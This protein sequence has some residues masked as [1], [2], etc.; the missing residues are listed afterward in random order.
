[1]SALD[2]GAKSF[3][4]TLKEVG[5]DKAVSEALIG[6]GVGIGGNMAYNVATGDSGGY[7]GAAL[8]GG[9]AGGLGRAGL[10]HF[11]LETQ[12]SNLFSTMKTGSVGAMTKAQKTMGTKSN[13]PAG[14]ILRDGNNER[15]IDDYIKRE[16]ELN[17]QA[18]KLSSKGY[19]SQAD[20]ILSEANAVGIRRKEKQSNQFRQFSKN[21]TPGELEDMY[22][23][24]G[25]ASY[26]KDNLDP[27]FRSVSD[28]VTDNKK[29]LSDYK[30]KGLANVRG[31]GQTNTPLLEYK[32]PA[33]QEAIRLP[34]GTVERNP[35]NRVFSERIR[36][37]DQVPNSFGVPDIIPPESK[38]SSNYKP[39]NYMEANNGNF[40]GEIPK[41]MPGTNYRSSS[42]HASNMPG[43]SINQSKT[44]RDYNSS[45]SMSSFSGKINGTNG[46]LFE[47]V[48]A[49]P[50][51]I[52][53]GADMKRNKKKNR[54]RRNK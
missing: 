12:A 17:R 18:S 33:E 20:E 29:V 52:V 39:Q 9:A 27:T 53:T 24:Q 13:K 44:S 42:N 25:G 46:N 38:V 11:N 21:K 28:R 22:S 31:M 50:E 14:Q 41:P 5:T 49:A 7:T 37:R 51:K 32:P 1:M 4:S 36:N 6:G 47:D 8:L 30:E 15:S 16:A 2:S 10:K 34:Y 19:D 45:N 23:S 26:I 54:R 35:N 43:Y 3:F 40:S 48:P